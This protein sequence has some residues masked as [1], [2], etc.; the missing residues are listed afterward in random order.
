MRGGRRTPHPVSTFMHMLH[1][2]GF[3]FCIFSLLPSHRLVDGLASSLV[4]NLLFVHICPYAQCPWQFGSTVYTSQHGSTYALSAL[5]V[6]PPYPASCC[7]SSSA[8]VLCF[9]L[10]LHPSLFRANSPKVALLLIP[11]FAAPSG[12]VGKTSLVTALLRDGKKTFSG[13]EL[14]PFHECVT[15]PSSAMMTPGIPTTHIVDTSLR[16]QD[17]EQIMSEIAKARA[18]AVSGAYA[19]CMLGETPNWCS[20]AFG[21]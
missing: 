9:V 21:C 4:R 15:I 17:E 18:R 20:F 1:V 2:I 6:C 12:N 3:L 13:D 16:T 14:P 10:C 5:L 8:V 7:R 11:A 19:K